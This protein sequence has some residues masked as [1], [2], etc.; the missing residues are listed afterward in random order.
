MMAYF[1][2]MVIKWSPI[3]YFEIM[4]ALICG[5]IVAAAFFGGVPV[6]PF[7]TSGILALFLKFISKS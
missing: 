3:L 5:S 6:G 7:I 2:R 4:P 1:F